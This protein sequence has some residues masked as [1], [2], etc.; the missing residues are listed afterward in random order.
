MEIGRL[1]NVPVLSSSSSSASPKMPAPVHF[2]M[3]GAGALL[4]LGGVSLCVDLLGA[5]I[6]D[7]G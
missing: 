3:V 4:T 5:A 6:A 7:E 1:E 2:L